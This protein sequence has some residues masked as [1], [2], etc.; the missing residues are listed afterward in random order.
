MKWFSDSQRVVV[1]GLNFLSMNAGMMIAM[2][3]TGPLRQALGGSW[4]NTLLAYSFLSVLLAL[5]WLVFGRD[6]DDAGNGEE[7]RIKT[8][9]IK[10]GE[11]KN[12]EFADILKDRNTWLL[13]L[14]GMGSLSFYMAL[15]TYFPGFY[16]ETF[17][18]QAD[19]WIKSAPGVTMLIGIPAS[20]IGIYVT[21]KTGKR[22]PVMRLSGILLLPAAIG[23]YIFK[24]PTLIMACAVLT[25]I[26]LQLGVPAFYCIPQEL[27]G[28]TP[29]KSGHMM[30]LFWAFVYLIATA[31]VW[32]AGRII[33]S[34]GNNY[35][36]GFIFISIV[37]SLSLIGLFLLPET[38]PC[39]VILNKTQ[40][41]GGEAL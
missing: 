17:K 28:A 36:N 22:L 7:K 1:N 24:I 18:N 27:P 40:R 32:I 41:H 23:M 29:Q 12:S 31:N 30:G 19:S 35:V 3:A 26:G 8:H 33:E 13:I 15:F 16:E 2:F 38:G 5:A 4:Q 34:N 10:P 11:N 21:Q 14:T 39:G 9:E 25:G 37:S 20:L 6:K